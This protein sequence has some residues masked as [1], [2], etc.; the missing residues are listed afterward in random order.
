MAYL[1]T[2]P[3]LSRHA[4]TCKHLETHHPR[5]DRCAYA[6]VLTMALLCPN[7]LADR[8]P[9]C[10]RHLHL[11]PYGVRMHTYARHHCP[12]AKCSVANRFPHGLGRWNRSNGRSSPPPEHAVL[13]HDPGEELLH[14]GVGH[15]LLEA[16][17]SKQLNQSVLAGS[18]RA[19]WLCVATDLSSLEGI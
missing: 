12:G 3:C 10:D 9:S 7:P 17:V 11:L 19:K 5:Q 16:R 8:Y 13:R 6:C 18:M 15:S 14:S 2:S 4:H 1:R